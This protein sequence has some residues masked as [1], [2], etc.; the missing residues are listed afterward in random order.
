MMGRPLSLILAVAVLLFG[1]DA[2]A[3]S[4]DSS[5]P[6]T[7]T[8]GDA[9]T[10]QTCNDLQTLG[11]TLAYTYVVENGSLDIAFQAAPAASGGWV[12]WGINPQGLAMI[13]TQALI[14]FQSSNGSTVVG[15]YDVQS[16]STVTPS[17]ISLTVTNKSAVYERSSGKITIFASL[18]LGSNQT[19]INQVWQVGSSVT[20]STPA[21]HS[22]APADLSSLGTLDLQSGT[23]S[24]SSGISHQTLKNRH[25]VLT[26]VSWGILMPIGIMIA[27]YAKTFKAADPAWFYLHAFCQTS[28]YII[29]VSGWGTGL[30]LGSYSKGVEQT[31]HRKI[32]IALFCF[33][34]LQI[35]A[36]LLR[37]KKNHKFRIYWNIY[38]HSVG[39]TVIILSIINI[40]KGF[41]ILDPEKKW[42]NAYIGVIIALGVI[43]AILEIVTW[44]IFFQRKSKNSTNRVNRVS[45]MNGISSI[46]SHV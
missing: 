8:V 27:R 11:A 29:G 39:Y 16:K 38:H 46:Q 22:T 31:S 9:K 45:E 7:F 24:V 14:A 26:V 42:K 1:W 2:S 12:A 5:C 34:T 13:G 21:I 6:K 33:A 30:K 44:I 40:F 37:P 10:Y 4:S 19:S 17:P 25:G 32:G 41:D 15:T 35:F 43:A 18:V 20:N 23:S 28:G 36:L 3:Q